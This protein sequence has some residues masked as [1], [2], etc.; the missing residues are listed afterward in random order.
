MSGFC[1]DS[2][3]YENTLIKQLVMH[4]KVYTHITIVAEEANKG[5]RAS[6]KIFKSK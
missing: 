1:S 4:V 5:N 3:K 2:H 6:E